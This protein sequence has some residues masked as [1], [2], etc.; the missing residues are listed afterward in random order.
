MLWFI[1]NWMVNYFQSGY[2]RDGKEL[3]GHKTPINALA[4]SPN[5]LFLASG[6]EWPSCHPISEYI[7]IHIFIADDNLICWDMTKRI[8][9]IT[10]EFRSATLGQVTTIVWIT[11]PNDIWDSFAFATGLGWI[12]VYQHEPLLVSYITFYTSTY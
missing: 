3:R 9:I 12:V 8:Q 11:K 5:T 6:C 4:L 2:Q 1:V 7:G 10:P